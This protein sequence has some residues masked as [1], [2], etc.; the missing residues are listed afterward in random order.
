MN[1]Q[2][3]GE[4]IGWGSITTVYVA[5]NT[6]EE[7][8][9][10][11]VVNPSFKFQY[12]KMFATLLQT[13]Q[14]LAKNDPKYE[15]AIPVIQD[16]RL[17]IENDVSSEDFIKKDARFYK[18]WNGWKSNKKDRYNIR[19]PKSL[20]P[21]SEKFKQE[22]FIEWINLTKLEKLQESGHDTQAVIRIIIAHYIEQIK[23]GMIHSDAHGGNFRITENNEIAI[24][25]RSYYLEIGFTE[26]LFLR[27]LF[28]NI[29]NSQK[30]FETLIE[31]L[32]K[33]PWNE[34]I[35]LNWLIS[36]METL[37]MSDNTPMQK[38]SD[39]LV[40]FRK[41]QVYI[42]LWMTLLLKNINALYDLANRV[43]ISMD[44]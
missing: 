8:V 23:D 27:S 9:V 14:S 42:P 29:H 4:C 31:Y 34:K 24:L 2:K 21:E 18:K 26:K 5:R 39:V 40:L 35:D 1:I 38:I 11:K 25:D 15:T 6:A 20:P 28:G 10:L 37:T 16:I 22:E 36:S 41:N 30:I 32:A 13:F 12:E 43:G 7:N 3:V 19:I 44:I 33:L 17:W